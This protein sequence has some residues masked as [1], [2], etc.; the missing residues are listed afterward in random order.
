MTLV[1]GSDHA[2]FDLRTHLAGWAREQGHTVKEVGAMSLDS[3]DYPEAADQVVEEVLGRSAEFGV[4]VCGTGIGVCIRANRYVGIRAAE[5]TSVEMAHLAR[6]HN[7]A[8]VLCLGGRI[9]SRE[10]GESILQAFLQTPEDDAER[11]AKRVRMLD[12]DLACG[13][14]E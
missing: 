12:G 11:H 4:L 14:Q 5:C 1:F 10:L 2:G 7:H 6:Q 13:T 3:Y 8:N 9:L